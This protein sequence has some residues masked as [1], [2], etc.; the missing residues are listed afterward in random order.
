[1]AQAVKSNG[2]IR[3][4]VTPPVNG[5]G[6]REDAKIMVRSPMQF[7]IKRGHLH[8]SA[9]QA[10]ELDQPLE[11]HIIGRRAYV[12]QQYR[13]RLHGCHRIEAWRKVERRGIS[14]KAGEAPS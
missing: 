10:K 8:R 1:L 13:F 5:R 14:A 2:P 4:V 6:A 11:T 9:A 7:C 3:M 12:V